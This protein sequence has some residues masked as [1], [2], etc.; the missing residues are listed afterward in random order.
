MSD[1]CPK[2][3]DHR[4]AISK[5]IDMEQKQEAVRLFSEHLTIVQ[6]EREVKR[7]DYAY[8]IYYI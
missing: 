4:D 3:E 1:M 5:A 6:K 7:I 8:F 2:C